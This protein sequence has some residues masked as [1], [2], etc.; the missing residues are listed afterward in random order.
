M[1]EKQIVAGWKRDGLERLKRGKPPQI[2]SDYRRKVNAQPATRRT[3]H[4]ILQ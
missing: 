3:K 1:S 4:V 2:L